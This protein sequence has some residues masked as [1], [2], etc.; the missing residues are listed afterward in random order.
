MIEYRTC[1]EPLSPYVPGRPIE[2][3]KREFKLDKVIK[4]ASNE[5]PLGCSK[6][7]IAAVIESLNEGAL[8]PDGSCG[9]LRERIAAAMN[10]QKDQL[11]FGAGTD[12]VISL[13]GKLFINPGDECV[14]AEVTFSQY[15]ASVLSM[16]GTMVY[17]PM[18]N[19]GYDLEAML[20]KITDKTKLIFIANP[21][22]PTGT[23]LSAQQIDKFIQKVPSHILVI[24]D[25]AYAEF[26][27]DESYPKTLEIL[28]KY[29]N[30]MLLKTFSKAYGLASFRVG[31]GIARPELIAQM[32]KIRNPFNVS[33]QGQV[34]ALAAFDDQ[35]FVEETV[36]ANQEV[37]AYC[38]KVFDELGLFYIPTYANFIMVDTKRDSRVLF[39]ELMKRGYI[40]RPGAAFGM[41]TFLRITI[42]TREEMEG[43]FEQL[44]QVL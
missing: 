33:V 7:A 32:E 26:V 3:V 24:F 11:I 13:I 27:K 4:L 19:H 28:K 35:D 34:A 10:I 17:A 20:Q 14:T 25:E 15:A 12:E 16:G 1:I 21:N 22:N 6:K 40:I 31:Y 37:L 38:C 9:K 44:R 2:D 23:M 39:Q 36:K 5:N 30:T 8:Y 29:A 42:G 43:F 18:K 41:D